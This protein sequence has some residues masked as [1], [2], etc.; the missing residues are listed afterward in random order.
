[1][2]SYFLTTGS[3]GH[4][5]YADVDVAVGA[6]LTAVSPPAPFTARGLWASSKLEDAVTFTHW[7]C[8]LFEV[9]GEPT[10]SISEHTKTFETL[11]VMEEL[12]ASLVLGPCAEQLISFFA[13]VAQLRVSDLNV[14]LSCE[15]EWLVLHEDV[16]VDVDPDSSPVYQA[17]RRASEF[18]VESGREAS[19]DAAC[20]HAMELGKRVTNALFEPAFSARSAY[21]AMTM[22]VKN[23]VYH[24]ASAL[25][26]ADLIDTETR[27]LLVEDWQR[28]T[29]GARVQ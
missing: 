13:E 11:T 19:R 15:D 10:G 22:A 23:A 29:G 16:D 3:D 17:L 27:G 8:R 2:T 28:I 7:P 12:D 20:R 24:V 1:M 21:N 25:A 18:A 26:V 6:T 4:L 9:A 5:P 14:V